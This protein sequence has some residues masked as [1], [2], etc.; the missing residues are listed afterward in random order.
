M[1]TQSATRR[2]ALKPFCATAMH[3]LGPLLN[4]EEIILGVEYIELR[5]DITLTEIQGA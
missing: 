4:V 2:Y 1:A 5:F 3:G